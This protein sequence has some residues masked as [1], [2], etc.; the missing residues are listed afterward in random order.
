MAS[1]MREFLE[2]GRLG[3]VRLGVRPEQ[4]IAIL[5]DPEDRSAKRRPVQLLRYGAVEFAFAPVPHTTDSRMVAVAIYFNDPDRTIPA[6]LCP[7][8]WNPLC[9]TTEYEFRRFLDESGVSDY[10]SIHAEQ[11]HLV[12]DSGASIVFADGRFHSLHFKRR[13][14]Q[15]TRKQLSFSLPQEAVEKLQHRAREEGVSIP[16]LIERMIRTGS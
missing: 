2:C 6:P 4:V 1:L 15:N 8:D 5:G 7:T 16:D 13:D 14:Q 3:E 12:L 11:D 9:T 10:S